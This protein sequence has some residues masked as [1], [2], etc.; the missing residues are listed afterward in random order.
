MT[1]LL[2]RAHINSGFH[3]ELLRQKKELQRGKKGNLIC[4]AAFDFSVA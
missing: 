1:P 4:G 3:V 2:P